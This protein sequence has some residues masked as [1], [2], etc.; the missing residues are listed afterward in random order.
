MK[1]PA[2]KTDFI[3]GHL[4]KVEELIQSIEDSDHLV[5]TF[6]EAFPVLMFWVDSD[7]TI[8]DYFN[9]DSSQLYVAPKKFLGKP[10]HEVIPKE[11]AK[12]I[13]KAIT[14]ALKTRK[15]VKIEYTLTVPKGVE[16]F[17]ALFVQYKEKQVFV[18][19]KNITEREKAISDLRMER[20]VLNRVLEA[21]PVG[22]I[23]VDITGKVIYAS[24]ISNKIFRIKEDQ[25]LGMSFND[26][27]SLLKGTDGKLVNDDKRMFTLLKKT[28]KPAFG[29]RRQ[30]VKE[31]G[32]IIELQM[33][34]VP[35]LSDKG[36]FE[37]IVA[38]VEDIT[39]QVR[40]EEALKQSEVMFRTLAEE[41]PNMIFINDRG[42]IL[43]VNHLCESVM[44]YTKE[45]FYLKDFDFFCL[46]APEDRNKIRDVYARKQKHEVIKT[47]EYDLVL[48][49][50]K[51]LAAMINSKM[52]YYGGK[53]V[54]L[55]IVTVIEDRK[56][57]EEAVKEK[58]EFL[59][60]VLNSA[61]DGIFVL[62]ENS[63][64]VYINDEC[65]R[66]MGLNPKDWIGKRAGMAV[67]PDDVERVLSFIMEA[68]GGE[69]CRFEAR[70]QVASGK[71]LTLDIK[72]SPMNWAGKQ[73][74]LG[75]ITDIT[76]H[77]K[78]G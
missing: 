69:R 51:R 47:V 24:R 54:L 50:G 31:D 76:K 26:R 61:S 12:Q 15:T 78:A 75:V 77:K 14:E 40:A 27:R 11:T 71:Y 53:E 67:H 34:A 28:R 17:E 41:S 3:I 42:R 44:G 48:K 1:E 23:V 33:N 49:D 16:T 7:F 20:A 22:I 56:R 70:L 39:D 18:I 59:E 68:I 52:I 46:I 74:V 45:E 25:V 9:L 66:I 63:N 21:S 73:Q 64:Y 36:E 55:G 29:I 2:N 8:A 43:Y 32:T 5:Q 13:E 38:T 6:S 62:D 4:R 35:L 57:A 72:L 58:T 19:I 60:G 10:I 30:I 37:G 65:G